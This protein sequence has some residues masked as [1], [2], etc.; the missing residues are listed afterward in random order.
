M[1]SCQTGQR[2]HKATRNGCCLATGP[3]EGGLQP[4]RQPWV[5]KPPCAALQKTAC[6]RPSDCGNLKN[7]LITSP[8]EL[9]NFRLLRAGGGLGSR[10]LKGEGLGGQRGVR[11]LRGLGRF[12]CPVKSITL[13]VKTVQRQHKAVLPSKPHRLV[14]RDLRVGISRTAKHHQRSSRSQ[15]PGQVVAVLGW[16]GQ[17]VHHDK[18][19]Q[20][21]TR[22]HNLFMSLVV[23]SGSYSF[24]ILMLR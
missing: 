5:K 1:K 9:P 16:V 15:N 13:L 2:P 4:H 17:L 20:R 11:G 3:S 12:H 19:L 10:R 14:S 6:C 18:Y 22:K 7:I 23:D 24:N 21:E 8:Q